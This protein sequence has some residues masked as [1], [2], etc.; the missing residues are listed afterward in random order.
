MSTEGAPASPYVFDNAGPQARTRFDSLAAVYDPITIRHLTARE[1]GADWSC[2]EVGGGGGSIALWLSG[3]VGA[4]GRV[5]VTDIDPT[6]LLSLDRPNVEVRR[7]NIVSD[8]LPDAAFDL[9]Y[10]RLV[11]SHLPAR[12]T[13]LQRM[14]TAL[15]PG[16]WL[17]IQDFD[18]LSMP[19]DPGFDGPDIVL[20]V[21]AAMMQATIRSGNDLRLGRRL[22][23]LMRTYGLADVDSE[24]MVFERRGSA[25]SMGAV[26]V[27]FDQLKPSIV[28]TGELTAQEVDQA[29]TLL[30]NPN[31]VLLSPILWTVWGRR[32]A[33]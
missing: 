29:L 20:K 8:D 10:S 4:D 18:S 21:Y 22:P 2:L 5:L 1:V 3:R 28:A 12:E 19:P 14:V 11:L 33:V 9:V 15:K 7:H 24:G 13:A 6:F 25:A 23:G 32:P 17:V 31:T 16:G 26:W 30:A 27:A